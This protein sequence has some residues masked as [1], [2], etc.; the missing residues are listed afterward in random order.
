MNPVGIVKARASTP[1]LLS[2]VLLLLAAC[3]SSRPKPSGDPELSSLS[4]AGRDAFARG[5][6]KLAAR[7]Y[8]M[9][10][11]RARLIDDPVEIGT[12]AYNLAAAYLELGE[13]G[14]AGELLE[15]ARRAFQRGPGV[16]S[17]LILLQGR[18]AL[19]EGRTEEVE[20]L[21]GEGTASGK[22]QLDRETRVQFQLLRGRTVL[23]GGDFK[24]AR[25][26]FQELKPEMK[27]IENDL[28]AAGY[29]SL[30][31]ELLSGE[32]EYLRAGEAF[33]REAELLRKAARYRGMTRARGRAGEAYRAAR[34]FCPASDRFYRAGRALAARGEKAAALE[35]V[36][37]ALAAAEECPEETLQ[38]EATSLFIELIEDLEEIFP[39]DLPVATE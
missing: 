28:I 38:R 14:R 34:E 5:Q 19:L 2:A 30:E 13:T 37:A 6:Y 7:A 15:E 8:R 21:I 16:P 31:G 25:A 35:M 33:D 17:D 39:P 12:V 36:R 29:L 1:L 27:K 32:G 11:D 3:A 22:K 9:A 24:A 23:A 4:R 20:R 18:V 10:R 26:I